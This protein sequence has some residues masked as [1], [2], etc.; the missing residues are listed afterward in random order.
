MFSGK[1]NTSK[2][3]S[4]LPGTI[5]SVDKCSARDVAMQLPNQSYNRKELYKSSLTLSSFIIHLEI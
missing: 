3:S 1:E 5:S 4:L 2:T